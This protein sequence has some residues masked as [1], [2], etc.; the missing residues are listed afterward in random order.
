MSLIKKTTP[1][2]RDLPGMADG[3]FVSRSLSEPIASEAQST[4]QMINLRN[5]F[6]QMKVYTRVTDI[7]KKTSQSV[8]NKVVTTL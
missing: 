3:G 8:E 6:K 5:D 1:R 2:Y 4:A 7:E